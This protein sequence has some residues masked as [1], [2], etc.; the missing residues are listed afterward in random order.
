MS[1]VGMICPK[2]GEL[3][4]IFSSKNEAAKALGVNRK[5][6]LK[7]CNDQKRRCCG[8]L[9]DDETVDCVK[10]VDRETQLFHV[11]R[12]RETTFINT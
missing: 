3:V 12:A 6:I 4:A 2:K 9:W 10:Y 5:Y 8:Y 7:A 1:R 11:A